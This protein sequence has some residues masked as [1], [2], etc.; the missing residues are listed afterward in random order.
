MIPA[1]IDGRLSDWGTDCRPHHLRRLGDLCH[2]PGAQHLAV[3][4]QLPR[5]FENQSWMALIL[6]QDPQAAVEELRAAYQRARH[7]GSD[8]AIQSARVSKRHLGAKIYWPIYEI[9]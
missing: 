8:A 4:E 2:K 9:R 1:W 6:T 5:E 3:R 7:G